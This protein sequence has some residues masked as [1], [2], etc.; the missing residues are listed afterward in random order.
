MSAWSGDRRE[1]GVSEARGRQLQSAGLA[2]SARRRPRQPTLQQQKH[3]QCVVAW[4]K[5]AIPGH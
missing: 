2:A 5:T 4:Q 3:R 1:K